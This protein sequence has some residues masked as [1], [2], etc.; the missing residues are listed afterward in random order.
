MISVYL[1]FLLSVYTLQ[2]S[3]LVVF[4]TGQGSCNLFVPENA[5]APILYDAGS[6]AR[7]IDLDGRKMDKATIVNEIVAKIYTVLPSNNKRLLT[8]VISHGDADH[9]NY[10]PDILNGLNKTIKFSFFLGGKKNHYSDTFKKSLN[11]IPP[12]KRSVCYA[13]DYV[14]RDMPTPEIAGYEASFL[15]RLVL[16]DKNA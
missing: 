11:K 1:W 3:E 2:A 15:A 7:P 5:S 4:N 9:Y 8:I 13:E 10:I 6:R 12:V 14:H 16:D